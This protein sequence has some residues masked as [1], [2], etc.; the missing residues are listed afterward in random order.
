MKQNTW[1]VSNKKLM[2][3]VMRTMIEAE[4]VQDYEHL[5]LKAVQR[6]LKGAEVEIIRLQNLLNQKK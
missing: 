4:Y 5:P 3:Q 1:L 6:L 2:D